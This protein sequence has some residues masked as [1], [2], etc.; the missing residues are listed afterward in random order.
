[1]KNTFDKILVVLF[2]IFFILVPMMPDVQITR[3][4]LLT[5]EILSFLI[6]T[7]IISFFVVKNLV[8]YKKEKV[9]FL[10]LIFVLYILFRYLISKEKPMMFNELKRWLI[11][12]WLMYSISIIDTKYYNTL[13]NFFI[14]GSFLSVI[15]GGLQIAG[16][17]RGF[18]DVPKMGRVMSM[19]G[20]PIFFAVHI[21][22]ILPI[23]FGMIMI[24]KKFLLKLIYFLI[25]A[26]GVYVLY[27]TKTRAAFIGIFV[28]FVFFIYYLSNSKKKIFY[29]ISLVFI[30]LIFVYVTKNIWLRQQ[31]HP[32]I[33]RDTLKM[34]LNNPIFGIGVGKFHIEFVKYASEDLRKIWPEKSFI[35]NDAHNEYIQLLAENGV[36][37]FLIFSI[38][39]LLFFYDVFKN[40]KYKKNINDKILIISLLSG[41]IAVFVQNIFS[42]DMR[43][44]ISNVYVFLTM[45]FILGLTEKRQ[46]FTLFFTKKWLKILSLTFLYIL[47]GVISFHNSSIGLLSFIYFNQ[48][49]IIK[50]GLDDKGS[51]LLQI[52]LRQYL[53]H[54][55]LSKEKDFFE[56]KVLNAAKTLEELEELR[57]KYPNKAII[58]EK[59]AWI[60]AKEKQFDKAIQNYLKAVELNP[61]SYA[62]YNN[63]GNIMFYINRKEAIKYYLKSIEI[64]PQQVDAR[65][66]LG[67]TYY[68]EGKLNLAAEQFNEVL[69][70]DPT[71]EK[72]IVYLKKMRE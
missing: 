53:S 58:Y 26:V 6:L 8:F 72:A 21:I 44:I 10:F 33:W 11:S 22:N 37:G 41:C 49:N 24:K 60:Y 30:F 71:N 47:F 46:E 2:S 54:Y 15:Y 28:A 52:I 32:V 20:N 50:F 25:F 23:V 63:L 17:I 7:F 51:G 31:A 48:G 45:G 68:Y 34:W 42:V 66:N 39:I 1:M 70:I 57:K 27:Y 13:L 65:I 61:N 4:K 19:F 12:F 43:F 35:I 56:E 9:F 36:I 55:R 29:L 69:K 16:G 59:I 64:N 62:S 40:L 38:P 67:I 18:V 5:I 14:F 3:P